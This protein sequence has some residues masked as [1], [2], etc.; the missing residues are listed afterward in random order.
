MKIPPLLRGGFYFL[1][2]VITFFLLFT[3]LVSLDQ[4]FDVQLPGSLLFVGIPLGIGGSF[5]ALWCAILFILRGH[6]TPAPFDPPKKFVILGPYRYVRN[7]MMIGGF[8][9]LL[10]VSLLLRSPSGLLF[11][12]LLAL[13][14]QLFIVYIEEPGLS[15]RFGKEYEDYKKTVPRWI[16]VIKKQISNPKH[17]FPN[18]F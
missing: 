9:T 3:G 14:F 1:F 8:S 2:L 13:L 17:Q 12:L 7:P 6:G 18:K 5:L 16:P 11:I 10:G 4:Y 15:D